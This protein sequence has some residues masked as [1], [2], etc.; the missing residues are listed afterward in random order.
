MGYGCKSRGFGNTV[1]S[2]CIEDSLS[3][4]HFFPILKVSALKHLLGKVGVWRWGAAWE[5]QLAKHMAAHM[6]KLANAYLP[7][8]SAVLMVFF[9]KKTE[10][11]AL[12]RTEI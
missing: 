2:S 9:R 11:N 8:I 4:Y 1:F 10:I 12:P 3:F 5:L 7:N 6:S